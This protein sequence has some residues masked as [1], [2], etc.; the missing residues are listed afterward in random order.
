MKKGKLRLSLSNSPF[1]GSSPLGTL[2][3]DIITHAHTST[4]E[5]T[6]QMYESWKHMS[7][8]SMHSWWTTKNRLQVWNRDP[9][10]GF[11]LQDTNVHIHTHK[12]TLELGY[13]MHL[14]TLH[15][16]CTPAGILNIQTSYQ[17]HS[18]HTNT[19]THTH[20]HMCTFISLS[21]RAACS[22]SPQ[23]LRPVIRTGPDG[24]VTAV[25]KPHL[26]EYTCDSWNMCAQSKRRRYRD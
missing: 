7:E 6:L 13:N 23:S 2:S 26:P 24:A 14:L 21:P 12:H 17:T 16:T 8:S 22:L 20:T 25:T 3:T 4:T 5:Y 15:A 11:H 1:S 19:H 18:G 10:A 9:R